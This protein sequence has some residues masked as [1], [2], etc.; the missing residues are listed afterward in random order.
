MAKFL[1][2]YS[3]GNMHPFLYDI[4]IKYSKI[5]DKILDVWS[6]S[7]VWGKRLIDNWYK[8]I[9]LIDWFLEPDVVFENFIKSDFT[10]KLPY[11]DDSFDFMTNLEVIEHV[12]NQYLLINEMLRCLKNW[13][14]FMISTPNI[15]TL[16]WKILFFF[17]WNLIGFL[18]K[19][20]IFQD[21]PA[22]INSFYL[23]S[24]LAY[25][26]DKI[27]LV[28][29]FYSIWKFPFTGWEIPI[30][31]RYFWNTVVYIFKKK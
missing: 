6:G 30:K 4:F 1:Q 27:E 16:I 7:W 2:E 3:Y 20:W 8:D 15:N 26:N 25:Y 22:H 11:E 13:G 9:Y 10:K 24:I 12:E 29:T 28:E 14:Y 23:P 21:F 18:K 31:N 17:T 5:N 19:D